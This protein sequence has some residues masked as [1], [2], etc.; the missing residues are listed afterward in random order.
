MAEACDMLR[1]D[2]PWSCLAYALLCEQVQSQKG[3]RSRVP[4]T[5]FSEEQ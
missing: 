1:E 3:M 2:G 5:C 4:A